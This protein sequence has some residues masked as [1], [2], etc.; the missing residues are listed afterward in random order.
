[1]YY[2]ETEMDYASIVNVFVIVSKGVSTFHAI[3][4]GP[5]H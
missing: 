1:M 3:V 4:I 5:I 2:N